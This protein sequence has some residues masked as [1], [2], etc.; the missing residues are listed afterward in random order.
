MDGRSSQGQ[1][2]VEFLLIISLFLIITNMVQRQSTGWNN[3]MKKYYPEHE[4]KYG[5][6]PKRFNQRKGRRHEPKDESHEDITL[7]KMRGRMGT[8]IQES[9]NEGE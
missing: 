7:G 5:G 9:K 1:A 6:Q 2:L 8:K 4:I 3:K